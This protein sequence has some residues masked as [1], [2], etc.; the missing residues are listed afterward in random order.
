MTRILCPRASG[1]LAALGLVVS[2]RRADAQRSVLLS[3]GALSAEAIAGVV[4]ELARRARGDLGSE[5][6]ELRCTYDLRYRGQAFELSV[7]ADEGP[8]PDRLRDA[9]EAEHERAYGY[10]DADGEVELV[11]VRVAAVTAG[12]EI[13]PEV[14]GAGS[15]GPAPGEPIRGPVVVPLPESTLVVPEGWSGEVLPSGTVRLEREP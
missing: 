4:A 8:D 3:G 15:A 12:P 10:R 7:E 9:F 14:A 2:E 6:G 5:R 11:T 1:V 13:D